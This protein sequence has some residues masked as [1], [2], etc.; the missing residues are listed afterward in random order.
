[1]N[2]PE[3]LVLKLGGAWLCVWFWMYWRDVPRHRIPWRVWLNPLRYEVHIRYGRGG[4]IRVN[5]DG[6]LAHAY[7]N[8]RYRRLNPETQP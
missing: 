3:H 4:S 2:C 1:M 5:P 6:R 8:W 7:A